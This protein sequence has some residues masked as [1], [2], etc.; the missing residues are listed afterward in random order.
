[1]RGTFGWGVGALES[2][3]LELLNAIDNTLNAVENV[4][5]PVERSKGEEENMQHPL[6]QRAHLGAQEGFQTKQIV[7]EI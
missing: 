6:R 1:M 4:S 5:Q 3:R 7:E 2:G